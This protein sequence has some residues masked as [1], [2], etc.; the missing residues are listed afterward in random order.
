METDT[1]KQP[2][3]KPFDLDDLNALD[4]A[5]M[6]V[7]S[8]DKATDW[9]WTFGGPGHPHTIAQ[10]ERIAREQLQR[11]RA[12]EMAQVNGKK[13]KGD[14]ARSPADLRE[15]NI[16]Y[17]LERLIGWSPIM[18]SGSPYPFTH[19]NART[20]LLDPRK[21]GLYQ[22]ALDFVMDENSFT[23]RSAKN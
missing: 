8:G 1:E 16:K 2:D 23:P 14:E 10:R 17:I 7:M 3:P 12:I 6:T 11:Q 5:R 18:M 15:S 4:E 22:Q 19:E 9:I 13:W 21:A 20:I